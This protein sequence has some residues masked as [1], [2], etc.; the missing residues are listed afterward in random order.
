MKGNFEGEPVFHLACR[1]P[2]E[3]A[4]TVEVVDFIEALGSAI[5]NLVK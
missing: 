2:I 3:R 4:D 5:Y 1:E